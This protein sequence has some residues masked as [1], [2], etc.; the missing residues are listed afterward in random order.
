MAHK[1]GP[2]R[3]KTEREHDL[4]ETARLDALGYS[5]SDIALRLKV[6]Q[7]QVSADLKTLRE[8]YEKEQQQSREISLHKHIRG[9]CHL[10]KE[11][12]EAWERSKLD[13]EERTVRTFRQVIEAETKTDADG[14]V[15]VVRPERI[16]EKVNTILH[17]EGRLPD[18]SYLRTILD[19]YKYEAE[20]LGYYAPKVNQLNTKNVHFHLSDVDA[21]GRPRQSWIQDGQTDRELIDEANARVLGSPTGNG[22][23]K[24]GVLPIGLQEMPPEAADNGQD[25]GQPPDE[26]CEPEDYPD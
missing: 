11:C 5:Q 9:L 17:S 22:V 3:T 10:R 24:E 1:G 15:M 13:H 4:A 7:P 8:R 18:N 16:I 14:N 2:K 26:S 6:S 19:T 12:I 25:N 23:H 21:Q 20:L